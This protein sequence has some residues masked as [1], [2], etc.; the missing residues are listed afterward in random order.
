MSRTLASQASTQRATTRRPAGVTA[1]YTTDIA[2]AA[3]TALEQAMGG[4]TPLV[5]ALLHAPATDE[6]AY[7]IGMIADPRNDARDLAAICAEGRITVGELLAAYKS[8]AMAKAQVASIHHIAGQIPTVV[9]DAM[10]RATPHYTICPRC[11]GTTQV[12]PEPTKARPNPTP[13]PCRA[14]NETGQ[15]Y[16]SPD[17]D[18]QKFAADLAGLTQ[19]KPGTLIDLSDRRALMVAGAGGVGG[20][21]DLIAGVDTLLYKG[22]PPASRSGDPTPETPRSTA[23]GVPAE[24]I[25]EAEVVPPVEE[26]RAW[27]PPPGRRIR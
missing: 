2:S 19:K 14:C 26:R 9:E 11:Q 25:L 15:I 8:G 20:F 7:V 21:A 13:E 22:A 16:V 17:L 6:L 10:T 27:C 24:T 3:L 18:R 1:T 12:T 4:R 23:A 5:T